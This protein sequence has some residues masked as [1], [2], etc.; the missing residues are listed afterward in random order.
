MYFLDTYILFLK[1]TSVTISDG[2]FTTVITI[3]PDVNVKSVLSEFVRVVVYLVWWIYIIRISSVY[4]IVIATLVLVSHQYKILQSYFRSLSDI[5]EDD[6]LRQYE[7]E[8]E[9]EKGFLLGIHMH[10]ETLR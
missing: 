6:K 5:F 10:Q 4:V 9:Y 2:T 1:F 7:M 3:W 8:R